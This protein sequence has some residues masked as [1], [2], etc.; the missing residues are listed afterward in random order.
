MV[1][2]FDGALWIFFS[3]C[4]EERKWLRWFWFGCIAVIWGAKSQKR[5]KKSPQVQKE[6]IFGAKSQ[7]RCKKSSQVQKEV[8]FGAKSHLGAD[9]SIVGA[10]NPQNVKVVHKDF[11]VV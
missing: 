11:K 4:V 2:E 7:K 1:G 3:G 9:D 10:R 6:V 8:V 5:C